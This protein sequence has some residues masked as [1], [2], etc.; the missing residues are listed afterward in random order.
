[1]ELGLTGRRAVVTGGSKGIG[2]AIAAELV[3]EGA[4]VSICARNPD[5]VATAAKQLR[6]LGGTVHEQVLDVTVPEQVT[7]YVDAAAGA[8]GGIDILVNNAGGAHPG[9]FET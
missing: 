9:T 5:E 1:M 2:L 7:G 4:A 8:L 3:G 6:E